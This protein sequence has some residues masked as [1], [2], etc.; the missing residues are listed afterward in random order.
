[1]SV[2]TNMSTATDHI[3]A[4]YMTMR[5]CMRTIIE[6]YDHGVNGQPLPEHVQAYIEALRDTLR[7]CGD[8]YGPS[9]EPEVLP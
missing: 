1:M 3:F 8:V 6:H 9:K 2:A 4:S 5:A 7:L